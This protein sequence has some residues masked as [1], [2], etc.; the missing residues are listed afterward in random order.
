MASVGRAALVGLL[1]GNVIEVHFTRRNK[2]I[3]RP[4]TRRMLC[5]NDSTILESTPGL[6][7]LNYRRPQGHLAYDPASKDLV[8]VWDIFMQDFRMINARAANVAAVIPR[9]EWWDYYNKVLFSMD[10]ADKQAFMDS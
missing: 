6:L 9:K 3:G 8:V 5:T 1:T 2:V 4:D 7:S 10:A